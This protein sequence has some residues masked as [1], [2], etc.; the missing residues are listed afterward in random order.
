M[1]KHSALS[2]E[3][4]KEESSYA[5]SGAKVDPFNESPWRYLIGVL[6]E[7]WRVSH[8][9]GD[10]KDISNVTTLIQE[11]IVETREMK[12][13]LE[14]QTLSEDH[15]AGPCASLLSALV[16]LLDFFKGEQ[17]LLHEAKALLGVLMSEDPVRRKYWLK[18]QR[19]VSNLLE[20]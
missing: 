14:E 11:I 19:E 7:Q 18:R 6:T 12:Q 4:A 8:R 15:P 1:N 2:Y 16:D 10:T 17:E 9:E 13:W 20:M 5:L 3:K